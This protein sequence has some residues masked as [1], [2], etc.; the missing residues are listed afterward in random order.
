MLKFIII[1]IIELYSLIQLKRYCDS[2]QS[3]FRERMMRIFSFF[4]I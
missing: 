2:K 1:I 4:V 3:L